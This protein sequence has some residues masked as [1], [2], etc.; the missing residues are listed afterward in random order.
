[1]VRGLLSKPC[2]GELITN[3]VGL[4]SDYGKNKGIGTL[5]TIPFLLTRKG[6]KFFI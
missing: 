3:H 2:G 1:M 6:V 5:S 4:D